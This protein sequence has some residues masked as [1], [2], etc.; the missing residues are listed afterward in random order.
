MKKAYSEYICTYTENNLLKTIKCCKWKV[1]CVAIF[2]TIINVIIVLATIF[3]WYFSITGKIIY[4]YP[5]LFTILSPGGLIFLI[6]VLYIKHF[7]LV[8]DNEK[9][10]YKL[11][12]KTYSIKYSEIK[13]CVMLYKTGNGYGTNLFAYEK[14]T[15][16]ISMEE[17]LDI[18]KI[19]RKVLTNS[20]I[21]FGVFKDTTLFLA[22]YTDTNLADDVKNTILSYNPEIN[23]I[24]EERECYML[25]E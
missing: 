8:F 14:T 3:S 23:F 7:E 9:I 15:V 22:D 1:T 13:L 18:K 25:D 4:A 2:A 17:S 12:R 16:C 20:I 6:C 10:I 5:I 21:P 24:Y 11:N 19:T